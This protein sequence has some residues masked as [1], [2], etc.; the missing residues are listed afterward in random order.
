MECICMQ[1]AP[2]LT[3]CKH[4]AS[5]LTSLKAAAKQQAAAHAFDE[6]WNAFACKLP[7][8]SLTQSKNS[9]SNLTT[10]EATAQ[11]VGFNTATM[12]L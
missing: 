7:P 12:Q 1:I 6:L 4:N 2:S 8:A 10:L 11:A 5:N 3:Q 9:A